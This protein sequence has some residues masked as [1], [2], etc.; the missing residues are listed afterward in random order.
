MIWENFSAGQSAFAKSKTY[1]FHYVD[2]LEYAEVGVQ[3]IVP[4]IRAMESYLSLKV[5]TIVDPDKQV[6]SVIT[7]RND[8]PTQSTDLMLD[9]KDD[10][11]A[12]WKT[13][14]SSKVG[15]YVGIKYTKAI[16]LK[17]VKFLMSNSATN[18]KNTF[19]KAKLQYTEDG[20]I[21]KDIEGYEGLYQVSNLGRI[22]S[23]PRV[24]LCVNR[25][26]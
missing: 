24:N 9:G 15:E 4:F 6:I 11:F 8:T 10:T 16:D 7:N 25:T 14:N 17:E 1:G 13:P 5:S 18:N 12:Q 2:H 21:W 19:A 26:L 22:Q 20:K 3:H 23:L